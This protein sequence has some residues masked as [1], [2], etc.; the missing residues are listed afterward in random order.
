M[1]IIGTFRHSI[2]LEQALVKLEKIGIAQNQLLVVCMDSDAKE[3]VSAKQKKEDSYSKGIEVG[4]ACATAL[5]V[6]GTSVGFIMP[7][8]PIISGLAA[9]FIGFGIG[10]GIIVIIQ[11]PK[12]RHS[13]KSPEVTVIV[14]CDADQ[15]EL[16]QKA[17]WTNHALAVGLAYASTE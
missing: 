12:I 5:S 7:W 11:K 1:I 15:S 14:Q 9:A 8:G 2:E 4:L 16:V 13:K 10:F 6:I 3:Y 17:M